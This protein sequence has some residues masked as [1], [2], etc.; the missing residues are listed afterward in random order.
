[1]S[2][3]VIYL[4]NLPHFRTFSKFTVTSRLT[5]QKKS[6]KRLLHPQ[7]KRI[8]V[9]SSL[10]PRGRCLL[11]RLLSETL[12][13]AFHDA[14]G[15]GKARYGCIISGCHFFGSIR[16]GTAVHGVIVGNSWVGSFPNI[17]LGP[18]FQGMLSQT[19]VGAEALEPSAGAAQK[20]TNVLRILAQQRL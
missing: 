5:S 1:M 16:T 7:T 9:W 20:L 19:S 12:A 4:K 3:Q 15:R 17:Y 8:A 18:F 14:G 6:S 10:N 13:S 11:R 2:N